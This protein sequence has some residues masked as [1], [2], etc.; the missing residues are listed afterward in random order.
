MT[1]MHVW[2]LSLTRDV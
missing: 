1:K 2:W